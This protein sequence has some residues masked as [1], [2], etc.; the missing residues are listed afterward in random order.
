MSTSEIVAHEQA[1]ETVE[2]E[3]AVRPR[4]ETRYYIVA[5]RRCP[6]CDDW[7]RQAGAAEPCPECGG[8]GLVE[9]RESLAAGL[10]E[11]VTR[12]E[13]IERELWGHTR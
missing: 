13:R 8:V 1:V 3:R 2:A 6:V 7:G 12:V 4:P 11:L 5:E 10:V 9:W